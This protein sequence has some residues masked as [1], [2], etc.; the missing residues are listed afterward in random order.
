MIRGVGPK[1][2]EDIVRRRKTNQ[3]LTPRQEEL[4][5]GKKKVAMQSNLF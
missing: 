1:M 2:A 3:I 4:L 5:S